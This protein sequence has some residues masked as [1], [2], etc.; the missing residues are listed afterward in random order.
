MLTELR[1]DFETLIFLNI[2]LSINIPFY[3]ISLRGC[4]DPGIDNVYTLS[5]ST[6]QTMTED[7][8]HAYQHE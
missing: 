5:N 6:I 7:I 8:Y 3:H 4:I 2:A 1:G